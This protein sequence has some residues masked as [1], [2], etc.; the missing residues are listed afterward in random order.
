MVTGRRGKRAQRTVE[1]DLRRRAAPGG[2]FY[3]SRWEIG[4]R[5]GGG[6]GGERGGGESRRLPVRRILL[7]EEEKL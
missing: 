2:E 4:W 3:C 1:S 5:I 7:G 6:E